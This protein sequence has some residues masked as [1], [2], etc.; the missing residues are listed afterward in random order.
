LNVTDDNILEVIAM[1]EKT[2]SGRHPKPLPGFEAAYYPPEWLYY[3]EDDLP[4]TGLKR[5]G[6]KPENR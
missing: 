1:E 6:R 5:V 3:D 4:E 2:A